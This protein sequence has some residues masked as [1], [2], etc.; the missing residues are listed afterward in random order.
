[1]LLPRKRSRK[2]MIKSQPLTIMLKIIETV[3]K[4]SKYIQ[5]WREMKTTRINSRV[6]CKLWMTYAL[7]FLGHVDPTCSLG[8]PAT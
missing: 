3:F 2:P 7:N 5:R 1:M 6:L 8:D 4:K